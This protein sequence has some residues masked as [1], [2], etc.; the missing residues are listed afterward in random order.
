[1]ND[2][3]RQLLRCPKSPFLES[4]VKNRSS[5]TEWKSPLINTFQGDFIKVSTHYIPEQLL[6]DHWNTIQPRWLPGVWLPDSR[7]RVC[8][9][10]VSLWV[11]RAIKN[12]L[13]SALFV[14][15]IVLNRPHNCGS[16]QSS[17]STASPSHAYKL[18]EKEMA[19][20]SFLPRQLCPWHLAVKRYTGGFCLL[21]FFSNLK[22]KRN[23]S[24]HVIKLGELGSCLFP[25]VSLRFMDEGY[26][27][28]RL[29]I[30]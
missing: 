24:I 6:K 4:R 16:P 10:S 19:K 22:R 3:G 29:E 25:P 2:T 8:V 7:V 5:A 27:L 11:V 26:I 21:S 18:S 15:L 17:S 1:M 9:C 20:Q 23:W 30:D 28:S 13:Q 12:W 14:C